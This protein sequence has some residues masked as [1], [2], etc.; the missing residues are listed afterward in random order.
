MDVFGFKE[1]LATAVHVRLPGDLTVA[2]A[3]QSLLKLFAWRDRRHRDR[4][5]AID[6]KT[7]LYAYHEGP[8][9]EELYTEHDSLLVKHDY[10][11]VLAG[12]ERIGR[13][14]DAIIASGNRSVVT[15]QLFPE[16]LFGTLAAEMGG[17]V[18][19]NRELLSAYRDGFA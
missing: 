12:A 16:E 3:A 7:I 2:V 8:Y 6:L 13:E 14:A 4:R 10:D 11:P 17:P 18:A 5:D 9:F 15:D 19:E 1:A